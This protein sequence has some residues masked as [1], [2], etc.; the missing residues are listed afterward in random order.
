MMPAEHLLPSKWMSPPLISNPALSYHPVS[1][2]PYRCVEVNPL[3]KSELKWSAYRKVPVATLDGEQYND[4]NVI[5]GVL[6]AVLAGTHRTRAERSGGAST[7][8]SW[9]FSA[10]KPS[11]GPSGRLPQTGPSPGAEAAGENLVSGLSSQ[12]A[13]PEGPAAVERAWR[14][15]VDEW[16]VRV[17]T[18]NIYRTSREAWQT[19]DYI[20]EHGNF[21]WWQRTAARVSGSGIMYAVSRRLRTRY[22]VQGDVREALFAAADDWCD[23]LGESRFL[24]GNER[25]GTA[26]IAM[27]GVLRS[28]VGTDS[29]NDVMQQTRLGKWYEAMFAQVG[30][31]ARLADARP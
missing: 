27:F 31:S 1:Q 23:A 30:D 29:F 13:A 5:I 16:F 19:F 17:L 11:A 10:P 12:P 9:W 4:S 8:S 6:D 18:V 26:D 28:V 24:A 15:W 20:T 22:G 3:T 21:S 14:R 2:L 25:P 7:A